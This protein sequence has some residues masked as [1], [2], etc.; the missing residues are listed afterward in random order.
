MFT[1]SPDLRLTGKMPVSTFSVQTGDTV[2]QFYESAEYVS[3]NMK[4]TGCFWEDQHLLHARK[5]LSDDS[6]VVD[7]GAHLGSHAIFYALNCR[8]VYAIEPV[9]G[10]FSL[11]KLNVSLN[12]LDDKVILHNIVLSDE[13]A[14]FV[15]DASFCTWDSFTDRNIG[16]VQF[17]KSP[18][19]V[20]RS[21]TLD[22]L[23][24]EK[25]DLLKLDVEG[26]EMDVLFG[27]QWVLSHKPVIIAEEHIGPRFGVL[28]R[29]LGGYLQDHGYKIA[30]EDVVEIAGESRFINLTFIPS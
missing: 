21:A 3:S 11:L 17:K 22:S 14:M 24:P 23:I 28:E 27:A 2:A 13:D 10:L 4:R 9:P 16:T 15:A 19:G 8:R 30:K 18:Y 6:I 25:V 29:E 26:A 1:I 12:N 20:Y 5:F 7:C